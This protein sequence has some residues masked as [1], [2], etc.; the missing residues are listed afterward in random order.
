MVH[1]GVVWFF[2]LAA[3]QF[4][5]PFILSFVFCAFG[6][7]G[8]EH[9]TALRHF[10]VGG[11]RQ[12]SAALVHDSGMVA[13]SQGIRRVWPCLASPA[14]VRGRA[15]AAD[16]R[17]PMKDDLESTFSM[18]S[19]MGMRHF[20]WG[21]ARS[22]LL[23]FFILLRGQSRGSFGFHL[24]L[25]YCPALGVQKILGHLQSSPRQLLRDIVHTS[26]STRQ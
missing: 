26:T 8:T 4:F 25:P 7:L 1:T 12:K 11:Q 22:C 14:I 13:P 9:R 10:A 5:L 2:V 23:L 20:G 16:S 15:G 24:V 6:S 21:S 3:L 19:R 18:Y 17:H